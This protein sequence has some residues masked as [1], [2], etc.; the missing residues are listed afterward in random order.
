VG[1][2]GSGGEDELAVERTYATLV[3]DHALLR[4]PI[5]GLSEEDG[6]QQGGWGGG[7]GYP[8]SHGGSAHHNPADL[9]SL[10]GAAAA[11]VGKLGLEDRREL[12]RW[13]IPQRVP[14]P[15]R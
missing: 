2:N 13:V 6:E 14:F 15:A 4:H 11:L 9:S 3:V 1:H 5:M 8:G 12:Q 7:R 10:G